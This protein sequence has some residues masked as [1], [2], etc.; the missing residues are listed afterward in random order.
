MLG[1][2]QPHSGARAHEMRTNI[3]PVRSDE[4]SSADP[5]VE[6]RMAQV[7]GENQ[8]WHPGRSSRDDNDPMAGMGGSQIDLTRVLR[9]RKLRR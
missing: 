4:A 2:S 1:G 8:A 9:G 6:E 3:R 7:R 5:S